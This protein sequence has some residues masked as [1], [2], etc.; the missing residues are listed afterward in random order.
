MAESKALVKSLS[1]LDR[2]NLA[3]EID[4][5]IENR[6]KGFL[7]QTLLDLKEINDKEL[8]KDLGHKSMNDYIVNRLQILKSQASAYVAIIDDVL[9]YALEAKKVHHDELSEILPS[10]YMKL[11]ALTKLTQKQR[12]QLFDKGNVMLRGHQYTLEDFK[13]LPRK[14]VIEIISDARTSKL[15]KEEKV[16][17]WDESVRNRVA[18]ILDRFEAIIEQYSEVMPKSCGQDLLPIA[19]QLSTWYQNHLRKA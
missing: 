7:F 8:Y 9:P 16:L 13:Q 19:R 15:P 11:T 1:Q 3:R 6:T 4:T 14:E 18:D 10:D 12:K 5:R 17:I 2:F